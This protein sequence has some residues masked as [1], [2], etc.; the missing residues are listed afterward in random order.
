[1]TLNASPLPTFQMMMLLSLPPDSKMF[2]ADGCQRTRPTRRY[3]KQLGIHVRAPTIW[4]ESST[5]CLMRSTI[6]SVIF[7]TK[8]ASGICQTFTTQSSDAEAITL[9]LWGHQA[10]SRTGPLW[11]PTCKI[12]CVIFQYWVLFHFATCLPMVHL[13]WVDQFF[14][15]ARPEMLHL[16][17]ILSCLYMSF[18]GYMKVFIPD[19]MMTAMNFGLTEQNV[20]SQED[21]D[22]LILS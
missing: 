4:M 20:E 19:S 9:S 21:F 18:Q 2:C 6:G 15:E 1:M 7:L 14:E 13:D 16:H 5:W 11:P 10:I 22:T 17:L 12:G 3:K 8:P